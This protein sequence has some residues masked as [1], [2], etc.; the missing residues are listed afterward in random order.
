MVNTV[1]SEQGVRN[2]GGAGH[3]AVRLLSTV[4]L[5]VLFLLTAGVLAL[6]DER[7]PA[8]VL[9]FYLL[10]LAV[11]LIGILPERLPRSLRTRWPAVQITLDFI[12][13]ALTVNV[14][15]GST[16]L[17]TSIFIV[18]VLESGILI[19]MGLSFAVSTCAALFMLSQVFLN[20]D[21]APPGTDRL[22]LLYNFL[23]QTLAFY[24]TAFMAGFWSQRLRQ[25]QA[26]QRDILD[27]MNSGFV[28]TDENGIITASNRA[29]KTILGT[30]RDLIGQPAGEVV[31]DASGGESP[32]VTALRSGRD[33]TSYEFTAPTFDGGHKLL[34]LTTS[35]MY[36]ANGA[37]SGVIAT[38]TDLTEMNRM[39]QEIRR[40]DRMAVV[41]E[42]AAGLAHE[43]RNPV[44]VIRGAADEMQRHPEQTAIQNRLRKMIMRE[45]DQLNEIVSGFLDFAREPSLKRER[46]NVIEVIQDV[47]ESLLQEMQNGNGK[48]SIEVAAPEQPCVVSADLSQLRQVF[49][50]LGKNALEAMEAGGTLRI[51]I[52]GG[53][54]EPVQIRFEDQG[55][56]IEPDKVAQIFEPFYTTKRTGVGMGLAVCARIL[57]AHDG[58][59]R[60]TSRAGGGCSMNITL[61]AVTSREDT[62]RE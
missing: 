15:G 23:V 61:P 46:T 41:G 34:G 54:G 17:F 31:Q 43:I 32:I 7:A 51:A 45:S 5:G 16:S 33:Y 48:W 3:R 58:T 6:P 9:A 47:R 8:Y 29:A 52:D 11:S 30:G 56:G 59:I 19:G 14:T 27:N 22:E 37:V 25:M 24:L 60:A 28:I 55:P 42:L 20:A 38:F 44:A 53:R 49:V 21:A 62:P 35:R 50:N 12:L 39:R 26:F 10:N 1:L 40:Q 2:P 57:T 13:V 36:E 4:R 18:V